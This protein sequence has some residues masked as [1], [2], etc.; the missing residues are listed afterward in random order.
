MR[1][2][3]LLAFLAV[4][5]LLVAEVW[6]RYS[7]KTVQEA[8]IML[9]AQ[10]IMTQSLYVNGR[11]LV[12]DVW[13]L[14]PTSSADPV[15]KA[16]GKALIVGKMVY[17][18]SGNDLPAKGDCT[19]PEDLPP[20]AITCDYVV[21]TGHSRFVNGTSAETPEALLAA[22]DTSAQAA[23]WKRLGVGVWQKGA[24]TLFAKVSE[25]RNLSQAVLLIQKDAK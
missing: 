9:G 3:F 17:A 22:L 7:G 14:P 16:R 25:G 2:A 19:Y 10:Q 20:W 1:K 6:Q 4:A 23:G 8:L 13:Q 21:E 15:R 24:E 5:S 11:P 12:A 18:F